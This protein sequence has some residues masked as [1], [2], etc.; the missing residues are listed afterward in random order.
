MLIIWVIIYNSKEVK[1]ILKV[2]NN[3]VWVGLNPLE[4]GG[5]NSCP[6]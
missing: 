5:F 2:I 3:I 6:S 1:T 4:T